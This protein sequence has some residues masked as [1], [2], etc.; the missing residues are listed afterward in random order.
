[1]NSTAKSQT[2]IIKFE[3]FFA[4]SYKDDVF[5]IL[6]KY[7]DVKIDNFYTDSAKNDKPLIDMAEHAFIVKGNT[8]TQIK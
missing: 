6:E 8:I 5:E 4:T 2:S 3:E 7:P 1:M